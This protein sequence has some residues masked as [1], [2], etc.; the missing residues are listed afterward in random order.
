MAKRRG[1]W[2][3]TIDNGGGRASGGASTRRSLLKRAWG[4]RP[5]T[6]LYWNREIFLNSAAPGLTP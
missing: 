6:I 4:T 1:E 5:V 2:R 3:R